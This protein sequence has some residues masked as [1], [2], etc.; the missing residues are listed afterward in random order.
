LPRSKFEITDACG[1]LRVMGRI[2][3]ATAR[4]RTTIYRLLVEAGLPVDDLDTAP[5]RFWVARD[6][7]NI[8]GVVGLEAY[9]AAGLLRSLVVETPQRRAGVGKALVQALESESCREGVNRLVLLTQTA[10]MFFAKQGYLVQDRRDVPAPI[11]HT[12]EFRSL[13]PASAVCMSKGLVR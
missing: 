4:D 2:D 3:L 5:V 12:A 10:Q 8:V 13:C 7:G 9:G 11:H 1:L 6:V